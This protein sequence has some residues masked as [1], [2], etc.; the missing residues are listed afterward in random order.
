MYAHVLSSNA[1]D[2]Q[3]QVMANST[4]RE[5]DGQ[6]SIRLPAKLRSQLEQIAAA[7]DRSLSSQIRHIVARALEDRGDRPVAA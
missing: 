6:V 1:D 2:L 3:V 7:E 4:E 5:T